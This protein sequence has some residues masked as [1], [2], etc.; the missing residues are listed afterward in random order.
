MLCLVTGEGGAVAAAAGE[1]GGRAVGGGSL[2]HTLIDSIW[3][4]L[5]LAHLY[6]TTECR[7][8]SVFFLG[9]SSLPTKKQKRAAFDYDTHRVFRVTVGSVGGGEVVNSTFHKWPQKASACSFIIKFA[10]LTLQI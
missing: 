10:I 8:A 7:G 5:P 9:E 2:K 4:S 1:R 3:F 6:V